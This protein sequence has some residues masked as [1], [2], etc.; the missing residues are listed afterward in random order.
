MAYTLSIGL[1]VGVTGL[2]TG[3]A[4]GQVLI[5]ILYAYLFYNINW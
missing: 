5:P 1:E 3:M 4:M 2:W